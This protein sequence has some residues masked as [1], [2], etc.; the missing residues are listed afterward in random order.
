MQKYRYGIVLYIPL[1][2]VTTQA[3]LQPSDEIT[4]F[5]E[6]NP[7]T[8]R[9]SQ[10]I[11]AHKDYINSTIKQPLCPFPCPASCEEIIRE[12]FDV[13]DRFISFSRGDVSHSSFMNYER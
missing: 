9:L 2:I 3:H 7:S 8:D 5:Y 11:P 10:I 12:T 4:I 13:S 6:V 1:F